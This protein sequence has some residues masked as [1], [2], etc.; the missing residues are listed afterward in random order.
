MASYGKFQN[1]KS[2]WV[3][4]AL[5]CFSALLFSCAT[6]GQYTKV[7][8][9]VEGEKYAEAL[10]AV[11]AA[12][13]PVK[14]K[15]RL[16]P[17]KNAVLLAADRGMISHFKGDYQ[18]SSDYLREG[19][20]LIEELFTKSVSLEV[21]SYIANDNVR[22]Y[23]GEDYEDVYIN[24]FNS[25]NYYHL[26]KT[27]NAMVEIRR[28]N[29]KLKFLPEKYAHQT[30]RI[31]EY[32]RTRMNNITFP[33]QEI[34][35]ITD[36]V[37]SRYLGMLFW[38][39]EG[40]YDSARIDSEWMKT[41]HRNYPQVYKSPLPLS[42]SSELSVPPNKA[43]L[44]ILSFAGLSPL[45]REKTEE[46]GSMRFYLPELAETRSTE[47]VRIEVSVNGGP[48]V[49]L[50]L[51]EDIGAVMRETYKSKY[52]L[53]LLK[54]WVRAWIKQIGSK[55]AGAVA[56]LG[57]LDG[58]EEGRRTT[59]ALSTLASSLI[60][61]T[62]AAD[63]RMARYF[64]HYVYVAGINLDPGS[65]S[66]LINYYNSAGKIIHADKRS[67]IQVRAGKLNLIE[68]AYLETKL[69]IQQPDRKEKI[70]KDRENVI[71]EALEDLSQRATTTI[72]LALNGGSE[73]D[74]M[75]GSEPGPLGTMEIGLGFG[76]EIGTLYADANIG[77]GIGHNHFNYSEDLPILFFGTLDIGTGFRFYIGYSDYHNSSNLSWSLG[78][79]ILFP[80]LF[81][82][83]F[84]PHVV[85]AVDARLGIFDLFFVGYRYEFQNENY[86]P[87]ITRWED[88]FGGVHKITFG[89]FVTYWINPP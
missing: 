17:D 15:N 31:K 78:Y 43:R 77:M 4:I 53:T 18:K 24:L 33:N 70:K 12:Q 32:A 16:Y 47:V 11:D 69:H 44:N 10:K 48:A 58:S 72:S 46:N 89:Y 66:L 55:A 28:M 74:I 3:T 79:R 62:E 71:A 29:D 57:S 14:E 82:P 61:E 21:A 13:A 25:L 83:S 80:I 6:T 38:R 87:K 41:T 36:T 34:S 42:V 50:E 52:G 63:T 56:S 84:E 60:D 67:N 26:G 68:S 88:K 8:E 27:D 1:M 20:R 45:K 73:I 9:L 30:T 5:I 35:N 54:T 49:R 76:Y 19:E 22:E 65:Y 81:E 59:E 85:H 86:H 23:S 64:P 2:F 39:G 75:N 7:D 40:N 51:L 37:F